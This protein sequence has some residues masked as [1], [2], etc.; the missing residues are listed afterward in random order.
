MMVNSKKKSKIRKNT[1][2]Y[3]SVSV[4]HPI[5]HVN[6]AFNYLLVSFIIFSLSV[7]Q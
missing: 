4:F 2:F 7:T 1:Y 3:D 5:A 6:S